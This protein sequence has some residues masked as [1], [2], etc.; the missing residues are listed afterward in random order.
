M[1]S[2]EESDDITI[3]V[4]SPL[5]NAIERSREEFARL[6][7]ELTAVD[8]SESPVLPSSEIELPCSLF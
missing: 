1:A 7:S 5:M 6:E 2:V 3:P 4:H 8:Q